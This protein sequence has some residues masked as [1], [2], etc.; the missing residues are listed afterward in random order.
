[1]KLLFDYLPII[2][3][4]ISFKLKGIYF[5]T[6]LTM[7]VALLQTAAIWWLQ[8]KVD[9]IQVVTLIFIVFLG[10]STLLLHDPIFIQWK[11]SIIY[12]IFAAVCAVTQFFGKQP[13]VARIL[14]PHISAPPGIWQRINAAW[15]IF[16]SALG[17][18]NLYVVYHYS[19]NTWVNFKLFGTL[20]LMIGFILVQALYLS[21]HT[22]LAKVDSQ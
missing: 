14:Q 17:G 11:P 6:A 7:L 15:A 22:S 5:A 21:R 1:M 13:V 19:M 2:I 10:S 18:L 20:G 16:F 12:W 3:F 8:K 4:F 9:K